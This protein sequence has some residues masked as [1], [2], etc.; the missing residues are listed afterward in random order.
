MPVPA[1]TAAS[2]AQAILPVASSAA[3]AANAPVTIMPSTPRLS[4]PARSATSSPVAA[5]TSGVAAIIT[6]IK[7]LLTRSK[8]ARLLCRRGGTLLAR[9][10]GAPRLPARPVVHEHVGR[11]HEEQEHALEGGD[12]RARQAHADLCHLAADADQRQQQ[13]GKQDAQRLEPSQ[14][15]DDDGG[16]AITGGQ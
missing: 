13:A 8:A 9:R 15:G 3:K 1:A 12:G 11:Q 7:M 14:E 5:S 16:K 10:A 4:T 6:L 2:S